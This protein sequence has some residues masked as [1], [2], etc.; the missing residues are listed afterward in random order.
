MP[1]DI[2][3]CEQRFQQLE[4]ERGIWETDWQTIVELV[5]MTGADFQR[6]MSPGMNRT[7]Q[8]W[9]GTAP[10]ALELFANGLHSH[11]TSV[12]DRW[13]NIVIDGVDLTKDLRAARWC[14]TVSD[15]I[16]SQYNDPL[17]DFDNSFHEGYLDLGAFGT[18]NIVQEWSDR[19]QHLVFR[20]IPLANSSIEDSAWGKV[21]VLFRRVDMTL[22][23]AQERFGEEALRAAAPKF[24]ENK[25]Q[26]KRFNIGHA[27]FPREDQS[28]YGSTGTKKAYASIWWN[29]ETMERISEGGY[30]E[31]PYVVPRWSKLPMEAYGRSPA[32]QCLPDIRMI[33]MMSNVVITAAQKVIDPPIMVEEDSVAMP[34][35]TRPGGVMVLTPGTNPPIPFET[36]GQINVGEE[37]MEKVGAQIM[38]AFYS[39]WML[40]QKNDVEMTATEVMDRREERLRMMGPML[41]RLHSEALGPCIERSYNLLNSRGMI[42]PC[43][44]NVRDKGKL[45]VTYES[46]AARAQLGGKAIAIQR[47]MQDLAPLININPTVMDAFDT[48]EL[49]RMAVRFRG[50]PFA[51]LRDPEVI[52]QIRAQREQQAQQAQAAED[53]KNAGSGI[54]SL[55]QAGQAAK[56]QAA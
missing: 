11:L 54:K 52:A 40:L 30:D 35:D 36:K 50:A 43:P 17:S 7:N 27:V 37:R 25:D 47:T 53:A 16:F 8:V 6:Q 5:R 14:D 39:D 49:A 44:V 31:F 9:D 19:L 42:P 28:R 13:F 3:L 51:I 4:G 48:D 10:Y 18:F 22:R 46:P 34:L 24:S 38:R 55:A 1:A 45:R 23:Q 33:N 56:G 32:M 26:S 21:N 20:A 2:K 29:R 12:T 41:G 15:I